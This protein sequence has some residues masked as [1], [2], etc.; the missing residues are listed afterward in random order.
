MILYFGFCILTILSF[1]FGYLNTTSKIKKNNITSDIGSY[2]STKNLDTES[3]ES[4]NTASNNMLDEN[5]L[6]ITKIYNEG[7]NHT[8]TE[9]IRLPQDLVNLTELQF[10]IAYKEWNIERFTSQEIVISKKVSQKCPKHYVLRVKDGKIA[11]YYENSINGAYLKE[12]T[13]IC[14]E[15]LPQK[16]QQEL[17]KGIFADSDDLLA[18]LLEDFGS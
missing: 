18:Q 6:L 16:D 15:N 5:T 1:T 12:I 9:E 11:V 7:C 14:V 2:E 17:Q 8:I 13:N 10:K 4:R 3:N